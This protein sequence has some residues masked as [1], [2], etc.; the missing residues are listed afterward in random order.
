MSFQSQQPVP[1]SLCWRAA[2]R[3]PELAFP[4]Y[5]REPEMLKSFHAPGTALNQRPKGGWIL[6]LLCP[7]V[8]I[9]AVTHTVPR[10]PLEG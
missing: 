8:T 9:V 6:Q 10:A 7:E 5:S 4:A 1:F 3:L 2:L